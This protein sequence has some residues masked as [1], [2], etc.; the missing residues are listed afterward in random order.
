MKKLL[1]IIAL[2]GAASLSFG[3]GIVNFSAGGTAATRISYTTP[4]GT[5]AQI[6]GASG[7]YFAL[8]AAPSTVTTVGSLDP[9]QTTGW[10]LAA[11]AAGNAAGVPAGT[12]VIGTN[13]ASIGRM[14]G[15]PTTDDVAVNG[16]AGGTSA[17]F[18]VVGWSANMGVT[19]AGTVQNEID[20][21]L[22]HGNHASGTYGATEWVGQSGVATSV[23]LG[24]GGLTFPGNIFGANPG[25]VPGF[26]LGAF[27]TVPEPS[28][29]ALAGLG[30]AALLIFRRRK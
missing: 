30:A 25:Q 8:F 11:W 28:T 14:T 4:A 9:T 23:L 29:F 3:Q 7:Y 15:N 22:S 21:L 6:S 19:W 5:N 18:V 20:F 2:A 10:G 27:T 26:N 12:A 24:S 16:Y 13:T 17:S 1:T